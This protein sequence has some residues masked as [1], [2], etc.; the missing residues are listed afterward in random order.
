MRRGMC[1]C[2]IRAWI[3][4]N[5]KDDAQTTKP[6]DVPL[7]WREW[8]KTE[9]GTKMTDVR[10]QHRDFEDVII[11]TNPNREP[12]KPIDDVPMFW[13]RSIRQSTKRAWES[14]RKVGEGDA[15]VEDDSNQE[16]PVPL[17]RFMRK[18]MLNTWQA[19][20]DE[21]QGAEKQKVCF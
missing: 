14:V 11:K 4:A 19:A 1:R 9:I 20:R 12:G 13:R 5:C 8:M 17:R 16:I 21:M 2:M 7:T 15:S 6:R 3:L 10:K 18:M